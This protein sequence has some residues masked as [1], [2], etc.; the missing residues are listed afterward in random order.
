MR[1]SRSISM[2]KTRKIKLME[3]VAGIGNQ[4]RENQ[5]DQDRVEKQMQFSYWKESK[6]DFM[7]D[8]EAYMHRTMHQNI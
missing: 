6:L 4:T 7:K 2:I 1:L 3:I 5:N 8:V